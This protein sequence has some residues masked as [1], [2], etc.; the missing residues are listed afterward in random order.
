MDDIYAY[1]LVKVHMEPDAVPQRVIE[2]MD[3]KFVHPAIVGTEIKD[4]IA[5]E[6]NAWPIGTGVLYCGE[7]AEVVGANEGRVLIQTRDAVRIS[8]DPTSLE[9]GHEDYEKR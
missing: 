8:V 6:P 2:Q 7:P 4:I 5:T 3:Y 9:R 1:V